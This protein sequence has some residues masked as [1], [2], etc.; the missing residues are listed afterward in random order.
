MAT[1]AANPAKSKHLETA[2]VRL[3]GR[4]VDFVNLRAEDY[5]ADSR[6]PQIAFGSPQQDA[7]R[8]DLT[9]NALF[10]NLR[11]GEVEDLTGRGLADLRAGLVRTPLPPR[12]T[13][14]DDPLRVLRAIRFATR[15]H[16]RFDPGARALPRPVAPALRPL[17]RRSPPPTRQSW[18]LRRSA[19]T[20]VWR[21]RAK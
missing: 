18:S 12:T 2:C 5:A 1:V 13:F 11:S 8:R 7:A 14:L 19:R 6:V 20:C 9:I 21:S 3:F 15:F 17:R 16:Y 4:A 10:Y